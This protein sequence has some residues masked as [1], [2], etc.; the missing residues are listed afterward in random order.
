MPSLHGE[1]PSSRRRFL[2]G[3]AVPD[4][5][6]PLDAAAERWAPH[7]VLDALHLPVPQRRELR[8]L[9]HALPQEERI[10][11]FTPKRLAPLAHP[12]GWVIRMLQYRNLGWTG[13]GKLLAVV[14]PTYL[15]ASTYSAIGFGRQ[16]LTPRMVTDFA[17]LLGI[18]ARELAALTSVYLREMPPPPTPEAVEAAALLWEAR[19]LS[20]GQARHIAELAR[21]MRGDSR[22]YFTN[23]PG[24]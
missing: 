14:T 16:E 3:L 8:Q 21:S 15:S 24:P 19:R 13:M 22:E 12:G 11:V 9:I 1:P 4:E 17:A 20:V 23:S 10:S 7:I 5:L 6:A 2:A 18:D